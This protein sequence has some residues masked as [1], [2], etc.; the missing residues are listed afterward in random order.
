MG[1]DNPFYRV[2]LQVIRNEYPVEWA[3]IV[4]A[5]KLMDDAPVPTPKVIYWN[6]EFIYPDESNG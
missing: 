4:K 3:A 2:G 5:K 6:G 1:K